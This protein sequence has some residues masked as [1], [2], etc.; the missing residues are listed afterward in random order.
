VAREIVIFPH[1]TLRKVC[2]PVHS[3]DSNLK[4]LVEEMFE[5]MHQAPGIGLAA[6]QV[7]VPWRLFVADLS[8]GEDPESLR[9]LVNPEIL[10]THGPMVAME[11]G[12]LSFPSMSAEVMRPEGVTV[13]YQT[14]E[15]ETREEEARGLLARVYQHETDHL[16]GV[17]FFDHLSVLKRELFKKKYKR[18]LKQMER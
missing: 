10:S 1:P 16:D 6:P 3:F 11:E 13:R 5:L 7:D 12:C 18:V 8:V 14:V 9:A 17:L 2:D 15:G 4:Q